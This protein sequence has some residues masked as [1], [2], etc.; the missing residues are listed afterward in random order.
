MRFPWMASA[1]ERTCQACGYAWLVP[2]AFARRRV[3]SIRGFGVVTGYRGLDRAELD[4]EV[5][6]SM[7][8]GEQAEAYA[9][10]PKCGS[11]RYSQRP[12]RASGP[13]RGH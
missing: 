11:E 6:S 9:C 12:V 8:I 7:E 3:T 4:S 13:E 1:Y 2:R 5:R 10:C